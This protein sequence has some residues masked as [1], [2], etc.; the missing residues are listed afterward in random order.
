M[1][2]TDLHSDIDRDNVC[3]PLPMYARILA[4][5]WASLVLWAL[6]PQLIAATQIATAIAHTRLLIII[7]SS[8]MTKAAKQQT[9]RSRPRWVRAH[10][11]ATYSTLAIQLA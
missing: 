7:P 10:S 6:A 2:T 11:S 4:R 1:S 8:S 5:L 3:H 9:Q